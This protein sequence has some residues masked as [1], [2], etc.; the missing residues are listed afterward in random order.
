LGCL[1][2]R[3]QQPSRSG[4]VIVIEVVIRGARR[5]VMIDTSSKSA[6]ARI[7]EAGN[8]T[9]ASREQIGIAASAKTTA[10]TSVLAKW[11]RN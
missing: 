7:E 6:I 2:L 8:G 1:S 5:N 9:N 10:G 4:I 3:T 11:L